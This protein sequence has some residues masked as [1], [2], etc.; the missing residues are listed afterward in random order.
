MIEYYI[1]IALIS[2]LVTFSLTKV[3][4][5]KLKK[6]GITGKD[7]NKPNP[8]D[9]PEMGGIAIV[10][11]FSAGLLLAI[12]FGSFLS[13]EFNLIN[14]LAA[15]ITIHIIAIIGI[16]DDLLTIPQWL[17][18]TLPL[19]AAIPLV[20]VKAAGS[21]EI[22]LP[23]LGTI[24]FGIF[25]IIALIPL[26]IA[27][28][29]NLTNMLAGFNGMEMGM[30]IVIF[31]AMSLISISNASIE[32][33]IL[34]LSMLGALLAFMYFNIYPAKIFPGDVGNLMIGAVLAS[35]VII[36]NLESAGAILVIPYV[37]DWFIKVAKRFPHTYQEFRGGKLYPKDA[38]IKGLVHVVMK[39]FNG[40]TERKLVLFFIG[41]EAIFAIIAVILYF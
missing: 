12:F 11:G 28:A 38:E 41:L 27:V 39:L 15:L 10:S 8:P 31:A 40:I 33:A 14:V 19:F 2:Y 36:G 30:G 23:L 26:G 7:E 34:S 6:A 16:I 20:A 37:A 9:I 1:A 13:F 3:L 4:I 29:S 25:Y 18:A 17:K 32:M 21:T 24:D 5:P 35:T 22:F